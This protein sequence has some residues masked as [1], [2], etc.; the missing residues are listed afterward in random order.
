MSDILD[1]PQQHSL[2]A[3]QAALD[4]IADQLGMTGHVELRNFGVFKAKLMPSRIIK[5]P[6]NGE[7]IEIPPRVKITFKP[8]KGMEER[9]TRHV[10]R[11]V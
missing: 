4:T 10:Q 9:V 1:V 5:H 6:Q 3:L 7:S 2:E 11:R 8:G